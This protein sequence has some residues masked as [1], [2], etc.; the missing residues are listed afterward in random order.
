MRAALAVL[1]LVCATLGVAQDEWQNVSR[2]VA[3]G[4]LHGDYEQYVAVLKLNGLVDE[5]LRWAG[6]T[7]H[8]VQL[9][10]VPDRGPDS[11][12]IIRHL[13]TL[14][15]QARR[16]GGHVHAL[17][18]NHE[19][20]NIRGDLRYVHPG[21]YA[22]LVTR[23]SRRLQRAYIERV[24]EH[25]V[26]AEPELAETREE[27]LDKLAEQFPLGYVEHRRLWEPGQEIASWVAGN[28]T[29]IK[30]DR[31]LFVHGGINPHE[32]LRPIS[33]INDE[34]RQAL[35]A[36]APQEENYAESEH[37]P[38]WYRGLALHDAETEL[39]PLER[40]LEYYDA[41]R[42]VI[43]HTPTDGDIVAR[44]E[45][46]VIMVDVGLGAAY[47]GNTASAVIKGERVISVTSDG[48]A[49]LPVS[50]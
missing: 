9:G 41:D 40:M 2:V 43:A 46:R 3:I 49:P 32:T 48:K 42:I 17:I 22:A 29:V 6:G 50:D 47:G 36:D 18:G 7:T 24:Y 20:M 39:E 38:L 44:F 12:K 28:N 30:I 10:D 4:D 34:I 15:R 45:G 31:V 19:A 8:L 16:A 27:T 1:A 26:E 11:L 23:S 14:A 35:A 25:L 37:G 5:R 13:M 21:E 33:Q